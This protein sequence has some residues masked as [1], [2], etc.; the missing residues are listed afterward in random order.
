MSMRSV[1]VPPLVYEILT[2]SG[3]DAPDA[4]PTGVSEGLEVV[5]FLIKHWHMDRQNRLLE[6]N[7]DNARGTN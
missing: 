2:W 3:S 6:K 5:Q 4:F 7:R 1:G